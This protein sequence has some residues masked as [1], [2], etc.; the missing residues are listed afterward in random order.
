MSPAADTVG[1]FLDRYG[2]AVFLWCW[3]ALMPILVPAI[4]AVARRDAL[5]DRAGYVST[6]AA[7]VVGYPAVFVLL[8]VVPWV[9]AEI[10]FVPALLDAHPTSRTIL[11]APLAMGDWVAANWLLLSL[12]ALMSWPAWIVVMALRGARQWREPQGVPGT[13]GPWARGAT[14]LAY[15][16]VFLAPAGLIATHDRI[17]HY[18][19]DRAFADVRLLRSVVDQA[20]QQGHRLPSDAEGLESLASGPDQ[21]LD[22][23]PQDPWSHPYIYLLTPDPPGFVIYSRGADGIDDHGAGDDI[24]TPGKSY[25]CETYRGECAGS[26]LWW[27][28]IA[29]ASAFLG[30]LGWLVFDTTRSAARRLRARRAAR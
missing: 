19:I 24:T 7:R 4:V 25:R 20:L 3:I 11:A 29:L 22:R 16:A 13:R 9:G 30:G 14:W 17:N 21:R 26:L 27:R 15:L 12:A 18:R 1:A 23:V 5:R 10:F 28:N 6:T 8:V 2:A